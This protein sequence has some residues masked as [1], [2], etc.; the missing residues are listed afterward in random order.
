MRGK[1][2]RVTDYF[3]LFQLPRSPVLG[4]DAIKAAHRYGMST[5]HPDKP[6]SPSD[7]ALFLNEGRRILSDPALRLRHLFELEGLEIPEPLPAHIDWEIAER[8]GR[9]L[10]DTR[11]LTPAAPS[12]S[13]LLKAVKQKTAAKLEAEILSLEELLIQ[14]RD[15]VLGMATVQ[16]RQEPLRTLSAVVFFQK[17]LRL[18][19]SARSQLRE[20]TRSAG[21]L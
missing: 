19:D 18:L 20:K 17:Q 11:G 10:E 2:L 9:A 21:P 16:T 1:F 8:V 4:L 13:G 3:A 7:A 12:D 14:N 15:A 5:A 6:N